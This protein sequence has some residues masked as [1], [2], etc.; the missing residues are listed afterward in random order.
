LFVLE[1]STCPAVELVGVKRFTVDA[2]AAAT[3]NPDRRS[4]R[5]PHVGV[6]LW[7]GDT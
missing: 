1:Q 7:R 2:P 5:N 4:T 6:S 3:L